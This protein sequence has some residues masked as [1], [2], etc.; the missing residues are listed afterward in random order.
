[1]TEPT[2]FGFMAMGSEC[3]LH[4]C[5]S[6]TKVAQA[7]EREVVRI[8]HRYSRYRTDSV[9]AQINRTA[10]AGGALEVDDETAALL[11]YAF[12]C[13]RKSGGLFDITTGIFR[14]AWDFSSGHVPAPGE[15]ERWLPF[16]GLDKIR[17]ESPKLSFSRAGMELDFGGI[18]KEYAADRAA[19]ICAEAGVTHGVVDLGGDIRAIGPR[20]DGSPWSI[21]IRDPRVRGRPLA[22]VPL[23]GG[24]LATSGDYER[25]I[26]IDGQRYGHILHPHTG[27]PTCGLAGVSVVADT[28]LIA[29]SV[30]TITMLKG[31]AGI[32]WLAALGLPC[33]WVDGRGKSGSCRC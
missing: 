16:V 27:W 3:V 23:V 17:W 11:D 7:A 32:P 24:G 33:V 18:G 22:I 5:D 2:R 19:A 1:M 9:L 12:A 21:S 6:G 31:D 8:E 30:S 4:L 28:C 10:A 13:H 20:P 26:T 15:I 14:R 25:C 29:G